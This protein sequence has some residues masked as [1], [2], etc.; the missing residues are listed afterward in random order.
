VFV[1]Y[2]IPAGLLAGWLGG[3]RL[4]RLASLRLRWGALAIAAVA[5]QAL[6]FSPLGAG[7]PDMAGRAVYLASTATVLVVV[8]ANGRIPGTWVIAAGAAANLAA[9]AANGGVMPADPGAL[10]AA[11]IVLDGPSNSAVVAQPALRPLTDIFAIPAAVP[12]ANVFSVGDVL[13]G[14]GV[15]VTVALAMRRPPN[16]LPSAGPRNQSSRPR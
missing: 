13:I 5:I 16:V 2:A 7:V 14:V 8:V 9:I 3:G 4:D 11:G 1:L 15:A 12:L 6:L 10:A